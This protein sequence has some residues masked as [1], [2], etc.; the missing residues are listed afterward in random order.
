MPDIAQSQTSLYKVGCLV[1][2][3]TEGCSEPVRQLRWNFVE[4]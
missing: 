3:E 2:I 1:S 4:E